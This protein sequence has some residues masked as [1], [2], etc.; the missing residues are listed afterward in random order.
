MPD[1]AHTAD[2]TDPNRQ[3]RLVEVPAHAEG[4]RLDNFLLTQL[5]GV[6]KSHIYR[7]I[8]KG[9]VRV[10][11]KRA[12]P[13]TRLHSA[14]LLRIPPVRVAAKEELVPPSEALCA[15]LRN[16]ILFEN[17]H[18][19]VI[20]KPQG[21]A[22]HMG[23][24]LQT[25]LIEALRWMQAQKQG[26]GGAYLELV[27]RIDKDTSGCVLIAKNPLILKELQ[28]SFKVKSIN[29]RYQMLVHGRWPPS[30]KKIDIPLLRRN[31]E[32]NEKI[33]TADPAGKASVTHFRLLEDLGTVSLVEA[34]PLTGRTHQIRVHAQYAGHP[35]VGD[36]KYTLRQADALDR[37]YQLCLHAAS[38]GFQMPDGEG[39]EVHAPMQENMT[40][41]LESL[42]QTARKPS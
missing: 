39:I 5:K 8:R 32:N 35:I 38:I 26:G 15:L 20:N 42:R 31:I 24:G 34:S 30:L 23:S 37:Q 41:L 9:E 13:D 17:Q 12:Q 29:K 1:T 10:N 27:H 40:R 18:I 11:K 4:Q 16:A 2:K 25:G 33:V 36:P 21:L 28:K 19:L 3:V 22:V 6:P 14:D 7:L